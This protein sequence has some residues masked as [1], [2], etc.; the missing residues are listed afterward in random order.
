MLLLLVGLSNAFSQPTLTRIEMENPSTGDSNPRDFIEIGDSYFFLANNYKLYK[1][2]STLEV[3]EL[4]ITSSAGWQATYDYG[5]DIAKIGDK[6]FINYFNFN[7]IGY[8]PGIIDPATGNTTPIA[9]INPN[10]GSLSS[11]RQLYSHNEIVYFLAED[12]DGLDVWATDGTEAGTV[13]ILDNQ[14]YGTIYDIDYFSFKSQ[15]LLVVN[16]S[17]LFATDGTVDGTSLIAEMDASIQPEFGTAETENYVYFPI[18]KGEI[19][20]TDGT[21]SGTTKVDAG[22][23]SFGGNPPLAL[24]NGLVLYSLIDNDAGY[25]AKIYALNESIGSRE[26]LTTLSTSRTSSFSSNGEVMY[27]STDHVLWKSDGTPGGTMAIKSSDEI[28]FSAWRKGVFLDQQFLFF[29]ATNSTGRELWTTDGST[30]GTHLL[31]DIY[32]GPVSSENPYNPTLMG[33]STSNL[34]FFTPVHPQYGVELW[35]SDGS[36]TGTKLVSDLNQADKPVEVS[37]MLPSSDGLFVLGKNDG[38]PYPNLFRINEENDLENV[39]EKESSF[40]FVRLSNIEELN[41]EIYFGGVSSEDGINTNLNDLYKYSDG[42]TELVKRLW[43]GNSNPRSLRALNDILLFATFSNSGNEL[44]KTNGTA[45]GTVQ[46]RDIAPG[47]SNA[48]PPSNNKIP[49]EYLNEKYFFPANDGTHGNELW[50][51]DL[52]EEGTVLFVDIED[53]SQSSDPLNFFKTDD[54]LFFTALKSGVRTLMVTDGEGSPISLL[55]DVSISKFF[56]AGS[57]VYFL[58]EYTQH[59]FSLWKTDGTADGTIEVLDLGYFY[60]MQPAVQFDGGLIYVDDYNGTN[61]YDYY[62]INNEGEQSIFATDQQYYM[63]NSL[64]RGPYVYYFSNNSLWF[65][66]GKDYNQEIVSIFEE[67]SLFAYPAKDLAEYDENLYFNTYDNSS[68]KYSLYSLSIFSPLIQLIYDSNPIT[69]GHTLEFGQVA[70][71]SQSETAVISITNNGYVDWNFAPET[72][73]QITGESASAF[74]IENVSFPAILKPGES[75][76][77]MINFSPNK[78]GNVNASVSLISTDDPLSE[79]SFN[80]TGTGISFPQTIIASSLNDEIAYSDIPIEL[81]IE[82]TSGLPVTLE[83]SDA[84]T[85][86]IVDGK[87]VTKKSGPFTITA[88]QEGNEYYLPAESLEIPV[89]IVAGIQTISFDSKTEYNYGDPTFELKATVSSGNPV[90]SFTS[91]DE[92]II[93][94]DRVTASI[95]KAGQVEI[96]VSVAADDLFAASEESFTITVNQATQTITFNPLPEK[97]FGDAPFELSATASSG[98]DVTFSSSDVAVASVEG[99]T[100]T[101]LKAGSATITASQVGNDNYSSAAA[102]QT[103]TINK[104]AQTI[105]FEAL[106]A[107]TFGDAPFA[108]SASSTSGLAV[109]Y[110]SSDA[111]V[112]KVEGT[113]VSLLKPGSATITASQA[114]SDNYRAA[115]SVEQSLV[116]SKAGQ[117]ISFEP[118]AGKTF[119]DPAFELSAS[120]STGLPITFTSS[121]PAVVSV[122]ANSA[123]IVKAGAVTITASQAGTD[124]YSAASA[125]QILTV[126]KASQTITFDELPTLQSDDE[127]IELVAEASSGLPVAFQSENETIATMEG[128]TLTITGSGTTSITATQGGDENYLAAA[129]ITRALVVE[130]VTGLGNELTAQIK[131]Y[132][133]P[134]ESF[135]AIELSGSITEVSYTLTLTTGQKVKEGRLTSQQGKVEIPLDSMSAGTYLLTLTHGEL[136]STWRILK[137]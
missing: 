90:S 9:D 137:N 85:A 31:K 100:V 65:T 2:T 49:L 16:S 86:E 105:T 97:T 51:T 79:I 30:D 13:K 48:L 84:T 50:M 7:E 10:P 102:T 4:A 94:I 127:P 115:A 77:L 42:S 125:E 121:D 113:N 69:S 43:Y 59:Y 6:I 3:S 107:K 83:S 133:N 44:W 68:F 60:N 36:Q 130:E 135:I 72:S 111:T 81:S 70:A 82:S 114:G 64:A 91:S 116:V 56:Q 123:S 87:L 58:E 35:V 23:I 27:F 124:N 78:G 134:T 106:P 5:T 88:S 34:C 92:S 110:A 40:H 24:V 25:V 76:E 17:E 45:E 41:G 93:K 75:F 53:G 46:I 96:T 120:S 18:Y 132:P 57:T 39:L 32:V 12:G 128:A 21:V 52:T 89:T 80:L 74:A 26:L 61:R 104:A 71:D 63:Y 73:V 19:W 8:E 37:Q 11:A 109:A 33:N 47:Q 131:V 95:L 108:L 66:D 99:V 62:Y 129:E 29:A 14:S 15:A 117:T 1:A 101:I 103:L 118:L 67:G 22:N 54:K 122:Q 20:R 126:A 55:D 38:L 98:L 119:G 28:Y 136:S 112:A